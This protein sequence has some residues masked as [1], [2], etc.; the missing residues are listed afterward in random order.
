MPTRE[1]DQDH[2]RIKGHPTSEGQ[3]QAPLML[4]YVSLPTEILQADNRCN[5]HLFT[6]GITSV[7][8]DFIQEIQKTEGP[9]RLTEV[10]WVVRLTQF[11]EKRCS[12][13]KKP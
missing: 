4:P 12:P 1:I 8:T 11:V 6:A 3:E 10:E 5:V 9:L 7:F 13:R 2:H